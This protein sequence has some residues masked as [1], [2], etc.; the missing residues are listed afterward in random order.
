MQILTFEK[1]KKFQKFA[2]PVTLTKRK[3]ASLSRGSTTLEQKRSFQPQFGLQIFFWFQ[4]YQILDIVP[5][6]NLVEYPGKL[7]MQ[8]WENGKNPNFRL[9]LGHQ[10]FFS[11][12]SPPLVLKQ[13]SK[14]SSYV[15]KRKAHEPNL[16]KWQKT[17]FRTQFW[18]IRPKLQLP[19][20]FPKKSGFV[21]HQI[22]WLAIIM[23]NIQRN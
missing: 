7:I 17:Y 15:I 13:C 21:S 6:C 9:N 8:P 23:Y 14:L 10:N 2:F 22:L 4:S 11:W 20:F 19:I 5:R 18:P 12:V 3:Q 1:S 16:R